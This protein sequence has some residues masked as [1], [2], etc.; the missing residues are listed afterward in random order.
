MWSRLF[1]RLFHVRLVN[2]RCHSRVDGTT[3]TLSAEY[4]RGAQELLLQFTVQWPLLIP[5]WKPPP[6]LLRLTD[7]DGRFLTEPLRC[8]TETTIRTT[9][10]N[11]EV[12]PR[13][14]GNLQ[15]F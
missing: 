15:R 5:R 4:A 11:V 7:T 3:V 2:L 12:P 6:L 10:L 13:L 9:R 14:A 1:Q 8:I